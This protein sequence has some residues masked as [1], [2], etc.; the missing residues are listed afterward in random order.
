MKSQL[1]GD[2]LAR[3]N[4]ALSAPVMGWT[5]MDLINELAVIHGYRSYLEICTPTTG[6]I[7]ADLDRGRYSISH[8]LM[9]RYRDQFEDGMPIDYCSPS[10]DSGEGV[11]A[12]RAAGFTYYV[13]LVDPYHEY[14]TFVTPHLP[15]RK[16]DVRCLIQGLSGHP[17]QSCG[18]N[19]HGGYRS[20]LRIVRRRC[21]LRPRYL[22]HRA[23]GTIARDGG[24]AP[25]SGMAAARQG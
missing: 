11:S 22:V 7:Y 4:R 17:A 3:G 16:P 14:E 25:P 1:A 2:G 21:R 13:I 5:K 8:R 24:K 15:R 9:Y 23:A 12:V 18:F 20:W 6:T 10:P 19:L